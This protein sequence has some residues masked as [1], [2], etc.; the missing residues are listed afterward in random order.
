V[1]AL[2][3]LVLGAAASLVVTAL[4]GGRGVRWLSI[5]LMTAL[6]TGAALATALGSHLTGRAHAA[7]VVI[8][9]VAAA[10][11]GSH[12]TTAVFDAVDE[13]DTGDSGDSR[14]DSGGDQPSGALE[15][16]AT[17]REA[18]S[19]RSAGQVLRGGAWIGILERIAVFATLVARWP[20]GIAIVLAVKGLGRYPELRTGR[21]PGLAERFI[22]GTL[23][24]VLWAALCAYAASGPALG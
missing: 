9:L 21:N 1:I 14:G 5:G 16:L 11:G 8:G 13:G 19:L 22:I 23:V 3:L 15:D 12:V 10:V 17:A 4:P 20:E 24:S 7:L 2:V 6:V 18:R